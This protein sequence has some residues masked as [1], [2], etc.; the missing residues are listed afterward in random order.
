M[1]YAAAVFLLLCAA[2]NTG[3]AQTAGAD[4]NKSQNLRNCLAGFGACD[5]SQLTPEQTKQ[6]GDI[7]HDRNLYNCL[8][9]GSICDHTLLTP[10]EAKEVAEAEHSRNLLACETT[11]GTC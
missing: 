11:V 3:F 8:T 1:K 9:T 10:T 7:L 6:I 5:R 4:S 2:T